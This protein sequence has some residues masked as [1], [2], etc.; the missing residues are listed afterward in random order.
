MKKGA[1][2]ALIVKHRSCKPNGFAGVTQRSFAGLHTIMSQIHTSSLHV[3]L[4]RPTPV[5]GLQLPTV[6]NAKRFYAHARLEAE[7]FGGRTFC[8]YR[9]PSPSSARSLNFSDQDCKACT[10]GAQES[11]YRMLDQYILQCRR[12]SIRLYAA[13]CL[14]G[15]AVD[16]ITTPQHNGNPWANLP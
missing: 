7:D 8:S 5:I 10:P 2:V 4:Q 3:L 9:P 15:R 16:L 1:D 11:G 14:R 6:A 13:L 12:K